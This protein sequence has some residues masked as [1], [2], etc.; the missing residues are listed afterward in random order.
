VTCWGYA[1]G[2]LEE[3]RKKTKDLDKTRRVQKKNHHGKIICNLPCRVGD[4][5]AG[6]E[7]EEGR[8]RL[9]G[10]FVEGDT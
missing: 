3:V 7:R 6:V 2:A 1:W 8:C 5:G 9:K 10:K 4:K